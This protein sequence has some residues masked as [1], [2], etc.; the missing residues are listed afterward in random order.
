ME[1]TKVKMDDGCNGIMDNKCDTWGEARNGYTMGRDNSVGRGVDGRVLLKRMLRKY[2]GTVW[3]GFIW[4]SGGASGRTSEHG[5][6]P[7]GVIKGEE[8]LDW[9]SDLTPQEGQ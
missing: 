8:F 5:D 9:L 1:E 2:C 4:L 3:T 7:S 6:E